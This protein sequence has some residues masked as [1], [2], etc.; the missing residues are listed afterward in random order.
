MA[1]RRLRLLAEKWP[2]DAGKGKN[3]LGLYIQR[4]VGNLK[5]EDCSVRSF[6]SRHF[7]ESLSVRVE[8]TPLQRANRIFTHD[9][10]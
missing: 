8:H 5:T 7:V 4:R 2:I 9:T 1:S 6:R 10:H 3:D